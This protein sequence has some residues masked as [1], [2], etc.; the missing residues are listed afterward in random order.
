MKFCNGRE[1]DIEVT[2]LNLQPLLDHAS[3]DF[4]EGTV[5]TIHGTKYGYVKTAKG[6]F[7]LCNEGVGQ[8]VNASNPLEIGLYT[9]E[10][11]DG[12]RH[13][14]ICPFKVL[15]FPSLPH[16]LEWSKVARTENLAVFI[17]KFGSRL[18]S[19]FKVLNRELSNV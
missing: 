17:R 13:F 2:V 6:D 12:P 7:V 3:K 9:E 4:P 15:R 10:I 5:A 11:G 1:S 16:L 8:Y 14:S 19:N 18:E